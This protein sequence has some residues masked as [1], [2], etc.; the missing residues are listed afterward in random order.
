MR[1]CDYSTLELI[2]DLKEHIGFNHSED[3]AKIFPERIDRFGYNTLSLLWGK[4]SSFING[5]VYKLTRNH[6]DF[7]FSEDSLDQLSSNLIGVIS[8]NSIKC[9]TS[10]LRQYRIG[11]FNTLRFIEEFRILLVK[12][13]GIVNMSYKELSMLLMGNEYYIKD[14]RRKTLNPN[15]ANYNPNFKFSMERLEDFTTTLAKI[16]INNNCCSHF[17]KK[18]INQ[19]PDLPIYP[20]QQYT[21]TNPEFFKVI[22]DPEKGYWFG[23][24]GADGSLPNINLNS[25]IMR[26]EISEKDKERL[27]HF[28][29]AIGLDTNRIKERKRILILNDEEYRFYRVVYISFAC[30]PMFDDLVNNGY[31]QIKGQIR[32]I[33]HAILSLIDRAKVK[34]F[35]AKLHWHNTVEGLIALAFLLGL[36][37]GDGNYQGGQSAIIYSS[38]KNLMEQIKYYYEISN[39]IRV[40]KEYEVEDIDKIFKKQIYGL[41]LGPDIF[42]AMLF[43][44]ENSMK[45]KRTIV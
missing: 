7:K 41:N 12:Y 5:V 14:L 45:R 28:S 27:I 10:F 11:R 8:E 44:Y 6:P 29:N 34:A 26:L 13:S 23:F 36:Y 30:K 16:Q 33:P 21:I 35:K 15:R 37:D 38:S 43:S 4:E 18:Y 19:N 31:L 42:N 2:E 1:R 22:D 32:E 3:L 24:L 9:I 17:I 40:I 20:Y 25:F 39:N